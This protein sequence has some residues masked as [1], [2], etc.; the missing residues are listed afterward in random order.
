MKLLNKYKYYHPL[1]KYEEKFPVVDETSAWI[2]HKYFIY[3]FI[4][5]FKP[6]TIV[7]LGTH[8]GAS[9]F[10]M[11]QAVKDSN[12]KTKLYAVDTWKGDKHTGFYEESVF[13]TVNKIK[14]KIYPAQKIALIRSL[15]DKAVK[16][17]KNGSIDLLHI[18]GLHTYEAVNHDFDIWFNKVAKDGVIIFHDTNEKGLDFGIYKLWEELKK[19]YKTLEFYHAHGLG[20]LFKNA[21]PYQK[22]FD[23]QEVWQH[24]YPV[25]FENK[26]LK[27]QIN[28]LNT[29][30]SQKSQE[31]KN[32]KNQINHLNAQ[33]SKS[34]TRIQELEK[35]LHKIQSSKTY[36]LWQ[37]YCKIRDKI[38]TFVKNE[39]TE[40]TK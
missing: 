19:K 7:E 1:F 26:T 31:N 21:K 22:I 35:S 12:L 8:Y 6:K 28:H 11:A 9:F 33:L 13:E 36:K 10:S 25:V 23:F 40:K 20:I 2:G 34:K 39:R 16:K 30:L 29:Q 4:R 5:N 32:L 37:G 18:D 24:Y 17:F 38:F 27:N 14:D 3:D 15:F